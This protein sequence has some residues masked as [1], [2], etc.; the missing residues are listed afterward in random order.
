MKRFS[1][2]TM[3]VATVFALS[4]TACGSSDDNDTTDP[5]EDVQQTE[6]DV[7][8]PEGDAATNDL[9]VAADI[10]EANLV[11]FTATLIGFGTDLPTVEAKVE[12]LNN[13]TGE[14]AGAEMESDEFGMVTFPDLPDTHLVGFLATAEHH[15]DTYQFYLDPDSADETLWIVPNS[16][17]T[18]ALG[19]AGVQVDP[20][21][22]TLAGA[23]YFVDAAGEEIALG[24][25]DVS[26]DPATDSIRYMDGDSG[27]PTTLDKQ[28]QTHPAH[29]RF[30]VTNL[31]A[32]KATILAKVGET[33]IG[34]V[35]VHVV[36]DGIAVGNIYANEL[37]TFG[38]IN[39]TETA[40]TLDEIKA[41]GACVE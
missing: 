35:E 20:G 21:K 39:G 19:L 5:T 9:A 28:G 25:V 36:G 2:F 12:L 15:K 34:S 31:A 38:G 29:G 37:R 8:E 6:D 33:L 14:K 41:A 10:E 27:L 7:Q 24:C 13:E 23:V 4:L 1:M 18:L 16:I 11:S 3:L 26:S 22:G 32:G 40:L 30:L 17:Y